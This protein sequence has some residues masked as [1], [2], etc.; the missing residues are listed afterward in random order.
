MVGWLESYS[1]T[2]IAKEHRHFSFNYQKLICSTKERWLHFWSES[3]GSKLTG[4]KSLTKNFGG[5]LSNLLPSICLSSR[6]LETELDRSKS[7]WHSRSMRR[8]WKIL[9]EYRR[10][11][12]AFP[13]TSAT[14][15]LQ[16]IET[17]GNFPECVA[18]LK[19]RQG[20]KESGSTLTST[21]TPSTTTTTT[22]RSMLRE[23][24]F[25]ATGSFFSRKCSSLK[26]N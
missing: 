1:C 19:W 20:S 7:I 11:L 21:S 4:H 26:I 6:H 8:I 25:F 16:S 2:C 10:R 24:S 14:P 17:A 22:E 9:S 13:P 3:F 15:P 18:D 5:K 23:D 12:D